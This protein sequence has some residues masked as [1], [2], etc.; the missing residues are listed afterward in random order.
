MSNCCVIGG[1]GFIGSYL[2]PQLLQ[3]GRMVTVIGLE[4]VSTIEL[5]KNLRYI[6]C[7]DCD[8]DYLSKALM[9]IDEIIDLAYATV[10]KTSFDDPVQDI[11]KNLPPTVKL[12]EAACA[13][14]VKKVVIVSSGGTVYGN[15]QALPIKEEHPTNPVSPYGITKL[16]IEKYAFMFNTLK[17][18]PVVCVR[19][20]NAYGEGQ[21]P[22]KGQGFIPTVIASIIQNREITLFG[23][24]GTIRDYIHASDISAGIIA[25]L[26]Y[27]HGGSVFNIGTGIG[28]SN[29]DIINN[30]IPFAA[31]AGLKIQINIQP[32][33]AFDVPVNILD[34]TKLHMNTGWKSKIEFEEWIPK[35]WD[36]YMKY[37]LSNKL[38]SR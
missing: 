29:M 38:G 24:N 25:A 6:S 10:P 37:D 22:F 14:G 18:L 7:N 34:S 11:L 30:I 19:P 1:N 17:L 27:G 23:S 12:L 3:T 26:E 31:A 20:G 33:R 5:A 36:W 4:P 35:A 28:R 8:D 2:V 32:T 13:A 15:A 21:K 9:G 16:A